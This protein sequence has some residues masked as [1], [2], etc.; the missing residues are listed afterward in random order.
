M[1]MTLFY[2]LVLEENGNLVIIIR[3]RYCAITEFPQLSCSLGF[4]PQFELQLHLFP[5]CLRKEKRK[6]RRLYCRPLQD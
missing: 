3:L 6:S 4:Q 2:Y 5:L 1:L